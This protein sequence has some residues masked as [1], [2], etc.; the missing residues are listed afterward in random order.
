MAYS[1]FNN[2]SK[3]ESQLGLTIRRGSIF[4]SNTIVPIEPSAWLVESLW[5]A[6]LM[7]F[8]S[9]KERS[10]RLISPLLS[11]LAALNQNELTIYSGH[12]L[13][14]DKTIGLNGEC[15]FLIALGQKVI[16]LVQTPLF[17]VVE[18]KRQDLTWGTAQCA[19]QMVGSMR[20][21][22]SH[23]VHPPYIYGATTDGIK[24]SFLKLE[25]NVLIIDQTTVL[26]QEIPKLLGILQFLLS[27]AKT[28][29]LTN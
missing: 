25:N 18:A 16:Q 19:A 28:W 20:Y 21:N 15:D 8:D 27:D 9:E 24:W 12:E 10:E 6:Q 29:G 1:N 4:N 14:V 3:I 17:S 23:N 22:I 26:F 5:R 2:L 11:E 13:N 7:G